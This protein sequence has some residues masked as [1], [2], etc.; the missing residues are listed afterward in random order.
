MVNDI[1]VHL[2]HLES[3]TPDLEAGYLMPAVHVP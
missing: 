3:S 2:S 1:L